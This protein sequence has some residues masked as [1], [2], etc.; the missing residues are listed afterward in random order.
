MLAVQLDQLGVS[1]AE[2]FNQDPLDHVDNNN[3]KQNHPFITKF[4]CTWADCGDMISKHYTGTGS[5]H[6]DV[7]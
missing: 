7:C 1:L 3:P 2:Q 6:T 4:K 5:T